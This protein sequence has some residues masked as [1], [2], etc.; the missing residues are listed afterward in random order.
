MLSTTPSHNRPMSILI[1]AIRILGTKIGS[2]NWRHISLAHLISLLSFACYNDSHVL[3]GELLA[4]PMRNRKS[5][6]PHSISLYNNHLF[7]RAKQYMS[8]EA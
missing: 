7:S 4:F 8:I 6:E 5:A 2:I 1:I 3:V